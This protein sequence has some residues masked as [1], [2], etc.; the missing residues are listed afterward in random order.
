MSAFS[1]FLNLFFKRKPKRAFPKWCSAKCHGALN[2]MRVAI[3]GKGTKLKPHDLRVIVRTD[4]QRYAGG[5]GWRDTQLDMAVGA[6]TS[7]NGKL[8]EIAIDPAQATN[9]NALH[10]GSLQ[11]EMAHHWLI[12][13]GHGGDHPAIYDVVIP[14]WREAR[15][16]TGR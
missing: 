7:P 6:I 12:S 13:N 14:G 5:W 11:H 10:Y 8:I 9:P 16:F 4:T 1:G 15:K 3:A 2:E